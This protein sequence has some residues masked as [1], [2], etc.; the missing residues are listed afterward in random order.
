M[1]PE[2]S[3]SDFVAVLN[4]T[5]EYAYPEVIVVGEV[6]SFKI[7]QNKFVFFDLKDADATV[8]CFLMLFNLRVPLEDGMKVKIRAV[9]KLTKFGKFSLTAQEIIPIGQGSIKKGLELLKE[10]LGKDGLLEESR[11]RP[12]PEAPQKIAVISSQAAAGYADFVKILDERWAGLELVVAQVAVQGFGAADQ[13]TKSLQYF[14]EQGGYDVIAIIRGGGSADDL[15]AFNDETLARAIASSK[16][17]VITGI[18]HEV[19]ESIADLVADIRASTPSNAAQMLSRDKKEVVKNNA[20]ALSRLVGIIS[21]RVDMKNEEIGQKVVEVKGKIDVEV[22]KLDVKMKHLRAVLESLNPE[23]VLKRGYAILQG[24][25]K[26]ENVV[27]IT[28]FN[29]EISALIKEIKRRR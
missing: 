15:A 3:V 20:S 24:E 10:K 9:P 7:N 28:T 8:G 4:Q 1:V 12:L 6:A 19:D 21:E 18:G 16:I 23:M 26:L 22:D 14:N 25:V 13:I 29:E 5:L 11:K 27:K 2:L 17:P